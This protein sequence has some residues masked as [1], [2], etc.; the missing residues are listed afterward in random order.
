MGS[1]GPQGAYVGGLRPGGLHL[2]AY[3]RGVYVWEDY[4]LD[5][6]SGASVWGLCHGAYVRGWLMSRGL[7]SGGLHPGVYVRGDYVLDLI[8]FGGFGLRVMSGG[9][10]P[11]GLCPGGGLR[12]KEAWLQGSFLLQAPLYLRT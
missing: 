9:L 11:G 10:C 5:F 4:V 1:F 7:M 12:C 6:V 2:A 3:I 8:C